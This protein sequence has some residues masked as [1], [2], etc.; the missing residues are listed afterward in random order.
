MIKFFKLVFK[1]FCLVENIICGLFCCL[2]QRFQIKGF[3]RSVYALA[4]LVLTATVLCTI[5]SF[6]GL[7]YALKVT[8]N[9]VDYGYVSSAEDADLAI[10]MVT[11]KVVKDIKSSDDIVTDYS[12]TL[13]SSDT[14]LSSNELCDE[15]ID[16][17]DSFVT[18]YGV[19]VNDKI[20]GKAD[21][22]ESAESYLEALKG[23]KAF[24]N[25]IFVK[26]SVVEKEVANELYD[27]DD[28]DTVSCM[29]YIAYEFKAN[30]TVKK[31]AK[32][33]D[34]PV[35]L[36]Y[37]LNTESK[38]EQGDVLNI[39]I[40]LPVLA[41]VSVKEVS[42]VKRVTAAQ[43]GDNAGYIS[44]IYNN[45]YLNGSVYKTEQVSSTFSV[46][47]P[48]KATAKVV[49]SVGKQ[50]FC[51]PV[52]KGYYQ[53][54]SS[55]WGDD[56]G[57]QGYDIAAK[58]GTPILS[59]LDG[60]VESV[61]STSSAYGQHFVIKHKNGLKT[62]Y[63]HCSTLYVSIGETVNRGE[64]VALVGNTGRSTG[65]HLHFEVI[66]NGGRVNPSYYIGR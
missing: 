32:N 33:F 23:D 4:S 8:V 46:K 44:E 30:D 37:A 5:F 38:F 31:V 14:I 64:V 39:V 34:I 57:H 41:T 59:V 20:I 10:D 61:N 12:F 24:F 15:I 1:V 62:L 42:S 18:V 3:R 51:W 47:H 2:K 50:G 29:T 54:V 25:N 52:D 63:A 7:T 66:K 9:G 58:T 45:Y 36:I 48:N 17:H 28:L 27:I 19:Y 26:E 65:S 13:T 22:V 60:V 53:Y 11:D 35:E 21:S 49:K 40:D 6:A 16:K 55:Y 56:R 43:T